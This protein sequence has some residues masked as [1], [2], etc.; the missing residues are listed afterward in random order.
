LLLDY[1][2]PMPSQTVEIASEFI[3]DAPPGELQDVLADVKALVSEDSPILDGLAPA[4][5]KYNKEQLL[6][7]KLPGGSGKAVISEYNSLGDGRFFDVGSQSSFAF[8]H[9]TQKAS[10]VR[11]YSLESQNSHLIQSL[12]QAVGPH[13]S[14]HYPSE[15]AFGVFPV[16]NDSAAAILVVGNKYSPGNYWNGRWRSTYIYTP[17]TKE[18]TG[19]IAVDVHYYEDGNVRLVTSKT[20][21]E[22]LN[23]GTAADIVKTIALT[24]RKYQEEMNKA[25]TTLNEGAFKNLR[26]QLPITRQKIDWDK[27]GSY[28]LG[29]DIGGG[30][31]EGR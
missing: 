3:L 24:E 4:I 19:T 27:I 28:R 5:E 6:A 14:E 13:V 2:S 16:N 26:R 8:D 30:R 31:A 29:Q 18:L 9:A 1:P 15:P 10:D 7:V 12:L 22:S 17:S 20:V 21:S 23:G 25:F 11:S